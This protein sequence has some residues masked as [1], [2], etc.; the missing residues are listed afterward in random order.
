MESANQQEGRTTGRW[1]RLGEEETRRRDRIGQ[2]GRQ[3]SSHKVKKKRESK[4]KKASL[5][6]PFFFPFRH[7][8]NFFDYGKRS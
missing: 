3:P 5:M 7:F 8:L 1:A 6:L 4:K 2:V